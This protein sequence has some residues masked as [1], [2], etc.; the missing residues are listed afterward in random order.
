M[1][2]PLLL[3]RPLEGYFPWRL[4]VRGIAIGWLWGITLPGR[5]KILGVPAT[6]QMTL[7]RIQDAT[8]LLGLAGDRKRRFL[9]GEKPKWQDS[10]DAV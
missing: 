10:I 7:F 4:D 8:A 5:W 1:I 6:D 2:P 9:E 3:I